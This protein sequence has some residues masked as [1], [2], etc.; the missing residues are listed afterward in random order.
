AGRK[1]CRSHNRVKSLAALIV[2]PDAPFGVPR[3]P[4]PVG[5]AGEL[6]WAAR[7]R[8][9]SG[10]GETCMKWKLAVVASLLAVAAPAAAQIAIRPQQQPFD[11]QTRPRRGLL[12]PEEQQQ[13]EDRQRQQQEE[14]GRVRTPEDLNAIRTFE[15]RATFSGQ[16]LGKCPSA[17]SIRA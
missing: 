11:D 9:M 10:Q 4:L 8:I 13:F 6:C 17:G 1:S 14:Q 12:T 5:K 2:D 15:G 7:T 3:L 16:R